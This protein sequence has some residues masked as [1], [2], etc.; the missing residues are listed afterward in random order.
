ME[1]QEI[2]IRY[3]NEYNEENEFIS[4]D[5]FTKSWEDLKDLNGINLNFR[6]RTTRAEKRYSELQKRN[7]AGDIFIFYETILSIN[8]SK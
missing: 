8:L 3:S 2:A 6:R 4:Q 7:I 1:R 5:P